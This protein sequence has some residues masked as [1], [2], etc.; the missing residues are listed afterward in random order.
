MTYD[1]NTYLGIL[2]DYKN[3]NLSSRFSTYYGTKNDKKIF[4]KSVNE[5]TDEW[6]IKS[7]N[8]EYEV[9]KSLDIP[10]YKIPDIYAFSKSNFI[11]VE[12]LEC[13]THNYNMYSYSSFIDRLTSDF[14]SL[15]NS[16][17]TV[18]NID[19]SLRWPNRDEFENRLTAQVNFG[20]KYYDKFDSILESAKTEVLREYKK[21]A[22]NSLIHGDLFYPNICWNNSGFINTVIDL[23]LSGFFDYI[24]DVAFIESS[25]LDIISYHPNVSYKP[26]EVR[27]IFRNKLNLNDNEIKRLELYKLWPYYVQMESLSLTNP[28]Y[29]FIE[30]NEMLKWI[31]SEIQR[32]SE[33]WL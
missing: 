12:W 17:K 16:F 6:S 3:V 2:D 26:S 29:I 14:T 18:S 28:D 13:E 11:A 25:I 9:Y 4:I 20:D 21:N 19:I 22:N 31:E 27:N 8:K 23:E 5:N 33:K 15:L 30:T 24:Y 32:I 10:Q 7:I 1:I